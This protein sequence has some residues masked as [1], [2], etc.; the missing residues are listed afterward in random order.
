M[1]GVVGDGVSQSSLTQVTPQRAG[2]GCRTPSWQPPDGG[3]HPLW[4][5]GISPSLISPMPGLLHRALPDVCWLLLPLCSLLRLP[6][7]RGQQHLAPPQVTLVNCP[8]FLSVAVS[9]A[10][11][12]GF[13]VAPGFL[14]P[15]QDGATGQDLGQ[16]GQCK[17][18]FPCS[19]FLTHF[20]LLPTKAYFLRLVSEAV[21]D[22]DV[23][24]AL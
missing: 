18:P 14:L 10:P 22:A 17:K 6:C 9:M 2:W 20:S 21:G 15:Q 5:H 12:C 16:G 13:V 19:A 24:P 4:P 11:S 7:S 23:K 8:F 1:G 3:Y